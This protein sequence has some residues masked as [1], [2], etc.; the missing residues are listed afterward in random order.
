MKEGSGKGTKVRKKSRKEDGKKNMREAGNGKL[1]RK[2][3]ENG[4]RRKKIRKRESIRKK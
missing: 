1:R 3:R 4:I 2:K